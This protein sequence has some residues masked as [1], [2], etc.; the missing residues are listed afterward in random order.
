MIHPASE[1][2]PAYWALSEFGVLDEARRNL[3][4]RENAKKLEDI[5]HLTRNGEVA[6]RIP[7]EVMERVKDWLAIHED[8]PRGR[9]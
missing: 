4:A 5:H 3:R 2:Q 1:D 7:P 8:L 9:R 6:E